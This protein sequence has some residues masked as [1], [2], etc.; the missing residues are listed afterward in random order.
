MIIHY[1]IQE[2][3]IQYRMIEKVE[4]VASLLFTE[5]AQ[6]YLYSRTSGKWTAFKHLHLPYNEVLA[7]IPSEIKTLNLLLG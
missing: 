7:L 6:G 5:N 3:E 2:G 4:L 1:W